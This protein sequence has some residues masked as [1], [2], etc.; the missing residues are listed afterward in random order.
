MDYDEDPLQLEPKKRKRSKNGVTRYPCDKWEYAATTA[1]N[2]RRHTKINY[3]G[4]INISDKREYT[5]TTPSSLKQHIE[6]KYE[7][8]RF[9][10]DKCE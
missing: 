4:V 3:E 5:A 9:P 2:L 1:C 10:C 6:S 7:G 8:V